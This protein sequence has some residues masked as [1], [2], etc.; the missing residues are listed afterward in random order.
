M[1]SLHEPALL[2]LRQPPY[3]HLLQP[4]LPA[5]AWALPAVTAAASSSIFERLLG[6]LV[7]DCGAVLRAVTW[8]CIPEPVLVVP[9]AAQPRDEEARGELQCLGLSDRLTS[10][11][12]AGEVS[13]AVLPRRV[14]VSSLVAAGA[15][16]VL[17]AVMAREPW[18][19]GDHDAVEARTCAMHALAAALLSEGKRGGDAC[20]RECGRALIS[21]L[22]RALL[23]PDDDDDAPHSPPSRSAHDPAGTRAQRAHT[24]RVGVGALVGALSSYG[25][26]ARGGLLPWLLMQQGIHLALLAPLLSSCVSFAAARRTP[27]VAAGMVLRFLHTMAHSDHGAQTLAEAVSHTGTDMLRVLLERRREQARERGHGA[28]GGERDGSGLWRQVA[29]LQE[30]LGACG[31]PHAERAGCGDAVAPGDGARADA[32]AVVAARRILLARGEWVNLTELAAAAGGEGREGESMLLRAGKLL[33]GAGLGR[34]TRHLEGAVLQVDF[35][36]LTPVA[37]TVEKKN[38]LRSTLALLLTLDLQLQRAA[39]PAFASLYEHDEHISRLM[40]VPNASR[41][42]A[43][44]SGGKRAAAPDTSRDLAPQCRKLVYILYLV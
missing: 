29:M 42:A 7:A 16:P 2:V 44:G 3:A 31:V 8:S 15:L 18:H 6:R 36:G 43:G 22:S 34:V 38:L 41:L 35:P 30:I 33:A 20:F 21:A 27:R 24:W 25:G 4:A 11:L 14:L 5:G 10:G 40:Q 37:L 23:L 9:R 13:A 17:V 28:G 19:E 1:L 32:E 39:Q 12:E 26:G